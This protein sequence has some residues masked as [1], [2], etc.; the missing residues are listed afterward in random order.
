LLLRGE[1]HEILTDYVLIST[2]YGLFT[3]VPK[4]IYAHWVNMLRSH[5][6]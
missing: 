4:S 2:V 1:Q 5:A 6:N 3:Y